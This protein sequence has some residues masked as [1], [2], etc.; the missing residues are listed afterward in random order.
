MEIDNEQLFYYRLAYEFNVINVK[1]IY[2]LPASVLNG[3][4]QYFSIYP[5]REDRE[6][7][8]NAQ[9]RS[10]IFN[11][12][13]K[14]VKKDVKVSELMTDFLKNFKDSNSPRKTKNEQNL[15]YINWLQ[16]MQ[17]TPEGIKAVKV[18]KKQN[19][20]RR[21]TKDVQ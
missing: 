14:A 19:I 3:W 10:T 17:T 4:R 7:I 8:R 21:K 1:E 11:I 5:F 13:G 20:K 6:D 2:D 15:E 9:L 16:R 12:S 18:V